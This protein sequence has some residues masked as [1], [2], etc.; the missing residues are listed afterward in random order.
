MLCRLYYQ[1]VSANLSQFD[2]VETDATTVK[3]SGLLPNT[4]ALHTIIIVDVWS[5]NAFLN[6]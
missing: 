3:L 6:L 1:Q 2:M 5:T 4:Q